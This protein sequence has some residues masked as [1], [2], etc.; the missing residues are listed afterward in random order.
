MPDWSRV[1]KTQ[2]NKQSNRSSSIAGGW[3]QGWQ[4]APENNIVEKSKEAMAGLSKT[5]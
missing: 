4:P 3:T 2:T 5:Q 1:M